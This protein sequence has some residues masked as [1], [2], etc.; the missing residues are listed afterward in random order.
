MK[1]D[2]VISEKLSE[3]NNPLKIKN[4]KKRNRTMKKGKRKAHGMCI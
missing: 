1:G 2:I 3:R 4:R